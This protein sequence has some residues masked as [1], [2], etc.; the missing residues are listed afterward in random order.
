MQ[1]S[2]PQQ[3]VTHL[4][5]FFTWALTVLALS[6]ACLSAAAQTYDWFYPLEIKVGVSSTFGE[7]RGNR[8]H[9]GV[10]L[11]TNMQT[12]FKVYAI[13]DGVV[14]RISV[15]RFGF[16][17]AL[18]ITHPNGLM[19]VYGHLDRFVEEG[20]GLRAIVAQQQKQR[21]TRYPGDISLDIRSKK[22]N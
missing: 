5:R 8:V 15:K 16:G 19:S 7:F 12:G 13:D 18:Y 17:N 2:R 9:T 21:K 4:F 1:R 11:R 14:S 6:S 10:D 3:H 20:L 22:G